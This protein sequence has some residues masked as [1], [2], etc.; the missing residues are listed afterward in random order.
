ME[1]TRTGGDG[2]N[3]PLILETQI[4]NETDSQEVVIWYNGHKS[5]MLAPFK[6]YFY[7]KRSLE[8]DAAPDV[9][10]TKERVKL[11]SDLK[12]HNVYKYTVPTVNYVNE[13]NKGLN[14][15]G[16]DSHQ[17]IVQAVFENHTRFIDRIL[18]DQPDFI[19]QYGNTDELKFFYFDIETLM[20]NYIDKKIITSIAYASN[21]RE[22]HSK[23]GS[24]KEILQ[25]FF[26]SVQKVDPDILVGYFMK[27]FDLVRII[28]RA[29]VHKLDYTKLARDGKVHYFKGER[30]RNV[31]M[32]IGGRVLWD[33]MDS[34]NSDQTIYGIKNKKMKTVCEWFGIEG[35][36]WVK[37][38]MTNSANDVDEDTLC[39][40]NEDDIRR[41]FGL[42][43]IYWGNI[44]TLAEMFNVP[45]D[46]IVSNTQATLAGIFMGR[47]LL[48]LNIRSTGMNQDRHP[49]IFR[50]AKAKGESNYEAAMVGIYQPGLHKPLYKIDFAGFYPSLMAAFNLSP[51]TAKIL[52]YQ[53]Y[54]EEFKSEVI[55][56]KVIYY[57]PDKVIGKT[58]I[59]GVKQ[60]VDGFLRKELRKIREERNKIKKQYKTASEKEKEILNSRQ[61]SLK[62]VQNIPSGLNGSS[63]S[64]YGDIGCTI[65]TVGIGREILGDLKDYLDKDHLVCIESDTDGIY[66]NEKLNMDEINSFLANLIATKFNLKESAEIS[67]DLDEYKAGYFIKQK[68]YILQNLNG[69]LTYHGAGMKSSRLPGIFDSA[70]DILCDALLSGET[71]LKPILNKLCNLDQYELR[72]FTLRTTLHKKLSQYKKGSLQYKLGTQAKAIGMVVEQETQLEYVKVKMGYA[73]I[74]AVTSTKAIDKEYYLNII[75]KLAENLGFGQ[76]FSTRQIRT[77]DAWW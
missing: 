8:F 38:D 60:N 10:E 57:I 68:N 55:G 64:R 1:K 72:D 22:V 9:I 34:V 74:Q 28:D 44:I 59:I 66:T 71:N 7:S 49:E 21:D 43:D 45:L 51:D 11:L 18:I 52:K 47:G 15:P 14:R 30:D 32:K 58:I 25:W 48:N 73:I 61:W 29:K 5:V 35:S 50:R 6:P 46:F 37:V 16:L 24:E 17:K 56:D 2:M 12:E 75:G 4:D 36:D 19:S 42:A 31:T 39:H 13:I 67:L 27:D 54:Q 3:I 33:L 53:P 23:Q 40:H 63:I 20:D 76:E 70:K 41:T 62:V 77:L 65:M 69:D 26:D